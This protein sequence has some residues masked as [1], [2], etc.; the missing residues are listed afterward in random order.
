MRKKLFILLIILGGLVMAFSLNGN[1]QKNKEAERNRQYEVSL[2][3]ALKNTYQDLEEIII[4][5]S[6][7][8]ESKPGGWYAQIRVIFDDRT[9]IEYGVGHNISY[10][11]NGSVIASQA[12]SKQLRTYLGKTERK[13]RVTY[14]DGEEIL[15]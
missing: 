14:S 15:E 5:R 1:I 13:I 2:V 10:K 4:I 11:V 9:S 7:F 3:K 8:E 6:G 12:V